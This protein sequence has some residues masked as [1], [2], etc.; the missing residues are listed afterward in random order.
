[1][2]QYNNA[3]FWID[4]IELKIA[5]IESDIEYYERYKRDC[6]MKLQALLEVKRSL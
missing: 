3:I 5:E 4:K 1:M 2:A 6:E